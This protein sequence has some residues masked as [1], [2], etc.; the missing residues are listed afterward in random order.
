MEDKDLKQEYIDKLTD[1][2]T[3]A[4]SIHLHLQEFCKEDMPYPAMIAFAALCA[5]NKI[6]FLRK[7]ISELNIKLGDTPF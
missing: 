6:E 3:A 5:S 1:Y 7:Q 4:R 2:P